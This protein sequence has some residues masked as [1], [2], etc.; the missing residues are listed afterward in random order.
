MLHTKKISNEESLWI[1]EKMADHKS[2]EK[3]FALAV[4]LSDEAKSVVND[5]TELIA[6]LE[7]MIKR[8]Y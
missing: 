2:V 7:T 3:S 8:S 6:I 5:D 4:K 1:K